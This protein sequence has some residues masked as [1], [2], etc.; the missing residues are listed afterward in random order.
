MPD[1]LHFGHP[2]PACARPMHPS[3]LACSCGVRVQA[4]VAVNEFALLAPEH[5]HFLRM[6]VTCE[7]RIRDLEASLGVSYPTVKARI[8]ALKDALAEVGVEPADANDD[9]VRDTSGHD[10]AESDS[11][12]SAGS[13][14]DVLDRLESGELSASEAVSRLKVD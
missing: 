14:D 3:A 2:C 9:R 5:L 4:P 13:V 7:G 12:E 1:A 6:F 8:K 10:S 11:T